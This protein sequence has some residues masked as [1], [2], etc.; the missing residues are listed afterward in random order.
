MATRSILPI[1]FAAF[2]FSGVARADDPQKLPSREA[3]VVLPLL[4]HLTIKDTSY[5][6]HDSPLVEIDKILGHADRG[7]ADS[8][9]ATFTYLLNDKTEITVYFRTS[10]TADPRPTVKLARFEAQTPGK[11]IEI[12]YPKAAALNS[13]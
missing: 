3:S 11:N 10:E 12:F 6:S 9:G 13:N 8:R 5:F 1:A 7:M 2:L 4:R